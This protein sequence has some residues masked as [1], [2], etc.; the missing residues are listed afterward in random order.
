MRPRAQRQ[1]ARLLE[2]AATAAAEFITGPLLDNPRR[3]GHRLRGEYAG[4]TRVKDL[5]T[6]PCL[7]DTAPVRAGDTQVRRPSGEQ[8]IKW[9]SQRKRFTETS[10]ALAALR[11]T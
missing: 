1:L 3:A 4:T 10:A 9:F 2:K 8:V 11:R 7:P 5:A 6:A